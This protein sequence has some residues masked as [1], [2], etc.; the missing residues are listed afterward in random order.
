[1]LNQLVCDINY[2]VDIA[3]EVLTLIYVCGSRRNEGGGKND[4]E[5]AK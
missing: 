2:S 5:I 1:M 4:T 3:K